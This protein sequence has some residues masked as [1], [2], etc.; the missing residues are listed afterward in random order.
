MASLLH[1]VEI[2]DIGGDTMFSN[3]YLAYE[4]LSDGMKKIIDALD[5]VHMMEVTAQIDTSS[6]ERQAESRRR[7]TTAQPLVRAHPETGR[8]ALFVGAY[9]VRR[10]VGFTADEGRPLLQFLCDHAAQPRFVYRHRWQQG[11]LLVWDNRCTNHMAVGDF[12]RSQ[13]RHMERTTVM[14]SPSGYQYEGPWL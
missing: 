9:K 4:S 13:I 7:N 8:K 11:D 10:I 14:G 5:A 2:P 1:A 6:T 12:D 3:L